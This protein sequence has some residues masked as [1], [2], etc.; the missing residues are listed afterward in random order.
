MSHS[1]GDPL[2]RPARGEGFLALLSD[3][4][5]VALLE[6]AGGGWLEPAELQLRL[7]YGGKAF[8][9]RLGR[10]AEMGL[11]AERPAGGRH[12]RVVEY[13]LTRAGREL[14]EVHGE[15]V[16]AAGALDALGGERG[17]LLRKS[18]V[19]RWDGVSL[20]QI[21]AGRQSIEQLRHVLPFLVPRHPGTPYRRAPLASVSGSLERLE[22]LGLVG[23]QEWDDDV[24]Y[25]PGEH[26]WRLARP[27]ATLARWHW[28]WTPEQV[29]WLASGDLVGLV[30]LIA[31]RVRVPR[32]LGPGFAL[33]HAIPPEGMRG[34]A[35][36]WTVVNGGRIS[37][38]VSYM[39]KPPIARCD[40]HPW[41][42]CEALLGGGFE[43][44]QIEGDAEFA[45]ELLDGLAAALQA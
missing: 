31:D 19:D 14:L 44:V 13:T 27:A 16:A 33:L 6:A 43:G 40:A 32:E 23:R 30:A 24:L 38:P 10:L 11:L 34:Q 45:R 37:P 18:I 22:R 28:R 4:R 9:D 42:W 5:S 12:R 3:R 7:K 29:P 17:A 36:V 8:E 2:E 20:R 1:P 41:T 21:L 15:L 39:L 25:E 26:A 35:D